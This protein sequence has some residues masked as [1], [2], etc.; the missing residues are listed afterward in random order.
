MIKT[1]K[2][3]ISEGV[4]YLALDAGAMKN[5]L[6]KV[7]EDSSYEDNAKKWS[8]RYRDQ[9]EKPLDRA[10]WWIEWL[11]RNPNCDY[12]KSPVLRLGF[13]AGN[14]YDIIAIVVFVIALSMIVLFKLICCITRRCIGKQRISEPKKVKLN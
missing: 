3:G 12:L 6:L 13:I 11:M 7:L 1:K 9:K 4:D 10:I 5:A 14:S 2:L 8:A